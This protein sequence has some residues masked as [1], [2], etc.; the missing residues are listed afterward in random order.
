MIE[1][2]GKRPS[3]F[4]FTHSKR[5]REPLCRKQ[6]GR[7]V[8]SWVVELGDDPQR[9]NCHSMR[10]TRPTIA[11]RKGSAKIEHIR[12]WL[13]HSSTAVTAAYVGIEVEDALLVSEQNSL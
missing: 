3:D 2:E 9:I 5:P 10:R 1:R 12:H 11:M 4:L 13:G 6:L 8:K 7:L